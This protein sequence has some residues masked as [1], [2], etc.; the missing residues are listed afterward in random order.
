MR[1]TWVDRLVLHFAASGSAG[2]FHFQCQLLFSG[3]FGIV[4]LLCVVE[5]GRFLGLEDQDKHS[6]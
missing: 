2:I 4:I 5:H 3:Y 1:A 6:W